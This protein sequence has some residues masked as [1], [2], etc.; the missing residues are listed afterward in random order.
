MWK[1]YSVCDVFVGLAVRDVRLGVLDT[2]RAIYFSVHRKFFATLTV[3][4]RGARVEDSGGLE[5]FR[6][7]MGWLA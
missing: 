2:L 4:I 3:G 1:D 5:G 6:L 7:E